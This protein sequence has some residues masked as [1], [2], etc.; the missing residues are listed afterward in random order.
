MANA[1]IERA[2][3]PMLTLAGIAAAFGLASCCA[4]PLYFATL[5]IGTA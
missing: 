3:S 5:G 1:K 4:L 2:A